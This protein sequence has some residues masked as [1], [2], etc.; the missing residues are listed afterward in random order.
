[1]RKFIFVAAVAAAFLLPSAAHGQS[2]DVIAEALLTW[3]QDRDCGHVCTE[4][5]RDGAED[6]SDYVVTDEDAAAFGAAVVEALVLWPNVPAEVYLATAWHEA[7]FQR[8][9][10]GPGGECGMFQQTPRYMRPEDVRETLGTY[11]ARCDYLQDVRNSVLSFGE[12]VSEK[13]RRFGDDWECAYN[14]GSS[15]Y[16]D[17]GGC[18]A[19]AVEYR[20]TNH[21]IERAVRNN[22][23]V[24]LAD[25]ESEAEAE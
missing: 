25:A 9:A 16:R 3:S 7:H 14:Q 20:D 12:N 2:A 4:Q 17:I 22:L 23:R 19:D 24:L 13:I 15:T 5:R 18:N 11:D 10:I 21:R 8:F 1:M 6:R